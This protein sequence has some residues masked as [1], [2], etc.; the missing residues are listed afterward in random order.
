MIVPIVDD[1]AGEMARNWEGDAERR[2]AGES[3][4]RD[5]ER[6]DVAGNGRDGVGDD[7]YGPGEEIGGG[8]KE[9]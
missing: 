4:F 9:K 8:L 6:A 1:G 2:D 7:E 5:N 3:T